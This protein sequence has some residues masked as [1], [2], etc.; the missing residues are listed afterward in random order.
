MSSADRTHFDVLGLPRRY[1]LDPAELEARYR[2]ESRLWHPDRHGRAP[3]AERLRVLQRATDLN[4]AYRVLR[5][6]SQ[7]AAYLLK[8]E[9][10]D[11]GAEG[12]GA[13][14]K[15]A[16]DFLMELLELREALV[17]A[18][19]GRDD[20]RVRALD[21]EVQGRAAKA[22]AQVT[23]GFRRLE[24]GDRGALPAI[25]EQLIALRYFQRFRDEIEAYEEAR[26][27]A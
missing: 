27:E 20:V 25:A 3:A 23:T 18:R 17:E 10:I 14:P 5:S 21:D 22:L 19:V 26:Q 15:V 11:I 16:P 12:A 8:L 9:G 1:A 7:R 4:E 24:E 6:D 13:Q 2:E